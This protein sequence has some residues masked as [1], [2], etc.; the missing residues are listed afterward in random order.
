MQGIDTVGDLGL[1]SVGVVLGALFSWLFTRRYYLKGK[2]DSE[3]L[4]RKLTQLIGS[5]ALSQ[6]KASMADREKGT[7][8]LSEIMNHLKQQFGKEFLEG[9]CRYCGSD[10]VRFE[11]A[12][13][14]V[15]AYWCDNCGEDLW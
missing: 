12:D 4:E 6:V 11:V 5:K 13:E 9:R 14:G 3:A 10:K 8:A 15:E 7:E 2:A 1:V